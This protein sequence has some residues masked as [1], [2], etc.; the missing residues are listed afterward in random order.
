MFCHLGGAQ[1][2]REICGGLATA[3]GKLKHLNIHSVP[4][5]STL[6]YANSHR[7]WQLYQSIFYQLLAKCSALPRK[8]KFRFR[9]RLYSMDASIIQLCLSMYDWAKYNHT[10]GAV[11]LHLA[12]DHAGYLPVFAHITL[13]DVHEINFAKQMRF[14]KGAVVAIDKGFLSYALFAKWTQE[15]VWF[16]TRLKRNAD[17]TVV[18][19]NPVPQDRNILSDQLI[20]F[21]GCHSYAKCP[22]ILRRVVAYDKDNDRTIEILTNHLEFGATTVAGIYKE[23]WQIEIFFKAIKQSLKIKTF[24]G[25]SEN[26]VMIQIWTA[27]ISI[28]VIKYLKLRSKFGWS[29]SNLVAMLRF[30]LF[31]Y[32]DLWCWLDNPYEPP[33]DGGQGTQLPL[34]FG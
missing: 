17:Y 15:G 23:R 19:D 9:N 26:A 3:L 33:P 11:K 10:K 34:G 16:V 22:H 12:M 8:H 27:L 1:S 20:R 13:G 31:A 21:S 30:S 6:A 25:I 4:N 18:E 14:P 5:K 24:V 32:R 2:L 7:P 29:L 28:L